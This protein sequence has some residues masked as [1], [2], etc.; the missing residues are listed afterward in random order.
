MRDYRRSV[1]GNH[2][3]CTDLRA[4]SSP[5]KSRRVCSKTLLLSFKVQQGGNHCEDSLFRQFRIDR[6]RETLLTQRFSNGQ[7]ARFV[8]EVRVR[9]LQVNRH[10][11]VHGCLNTGILQGRAHPVALWSFNN[12]TMP[13]EV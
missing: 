7:I 13:Q 2:R 1:T 3:P 9:L 8:T 11:V 4:D 6:E 5:G 10:R 12:V